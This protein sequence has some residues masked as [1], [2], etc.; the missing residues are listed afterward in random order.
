MSRPIEANNI[1]VLQVRDKV[2]KRIRG[3]PQAVNEE[4]G[5]AIWIT[6]SLE[7]DMAI[8]PLK[9]TQTTNFRRHP[10][11]VRVEICY[12]SLCAMVMNV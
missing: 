12:A 4:D 3:A 10:V 8:W 6:L 7:K 11:R 9:V 2:L 5:L 1:A